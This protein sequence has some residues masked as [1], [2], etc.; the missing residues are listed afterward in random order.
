MNILVDIRPLLDERYSGVAEYT[1]ELLK[2]LL[3]RDT[4]N[5]YFLFYNSFH[6]L[7]HRLPI[8]SQENVTMIKMKLPNKVLNYPLLKILHRPYLDRLAKT[9]IDIFFMPHLNFAAW[10]RSAKMILTVHDLSF[11]HYPRFFSLHKNIWHWLLAVKRLLRRA[12][13]IV[14]LSENTKQDIV[15]YGKVSSDKVSVI[16]SGISEVFRTIDADD[17]QLQAIKEKYQLPSRFLL[18]LGTV[19]PRKN[20]QTLIQAFAMIKSQAG[21]EDLHLVIAGGRGWKADPIYRTAKNSPYRQFIK[22]LDYVPAEE[23]VY[24]YNLATVFI[25]PSF[26]EGF[27]FPPLEAMACG[28]PTIVSNV[29]SLPEVVENAALMIDPYNTAA[30]SRAIISLLEDERLAQHYTEAGPQ[31][32]ALFQWDKA[33]GAYLELFKKIVTS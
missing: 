26:Y 28:T 1:F 3:Q 19:E 4:E 22:F 10:S 33:A 29:S 31:Q 17:N 20:L 21:Y 15:A 13:H 7:E 30:L 2:A 16:Y 11:V 27:G 18:F 8:F 14:S 9:K 23:K 32:A 6:N 25:Y 5:Q 12:H 24:L